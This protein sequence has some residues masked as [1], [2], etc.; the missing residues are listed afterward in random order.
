MSALERRPLGHTGL[1]VTRIGFGALEIG[2]DWGLGDAAA[3]R[4]P[5]E[6]QAGVVLH[7]VLDLGINLIDTA[8]AYHRSE[9]RIGHSLAPRRQAYVLATKCGEHSAEPRTYYDFS[10]RAV[11]ASIDLSLRL[12][13]T[14]MID[15]LQIHFGPEP[16]KVLEDGETL[17]AMKDAREAG[18]VRFLG[19]SPGHDLLERCI[20][21][22]EFDVLQV[23]YSLL[24]RGAHDLITKAGDRGI[25]ILIRSGLGGG[26]LTARAL[27]VPPDQR[28]APVNRL[29]ALVNGDG[30]RLHRLA[31]AFLR[32]H[33]AISAILVGTKHLDHLRRNLERFRSPEDGDL[34]QRARA[35]V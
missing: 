32:A 4:K 25:G 29:L 8:R 18:K 6:A 15:V 5:T 17:R 23:G 35:E 16:A 34:L 21:C 30:E 24:E 26:W 22:G 20:A 9:E 3:Q 14:E 28:P 7:G 31:L 2:R 10:Y 33:P 11:S 27:T 12:L 13:Q 1:E 19:A